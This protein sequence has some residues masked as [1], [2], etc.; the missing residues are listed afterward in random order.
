MNPDFS[1]NYSIPGYT[2]ITKCGKQ[3]NK[4]VK[5]RSGGLLCYMKDSISSGINQI[6]GIVENDDRLWLKLHSSFFTLRNDVYIICC[7]YITPATSTSTSARENIWP[8]LTTEVAKFSRQGDIL[9]TGNFNARTSDLPDYNQYDSLP[10]PAD[11]TSD[12]GQTRC[13]SDH[14]VYSYGKVLLNLCI[15]SNLRIVNGRIGTDRNVGEFTCYSPRG[16][17]VVDYFVVSAHLMSYISDMSVSDHSEYSDHCPI[18]L[19][20]KSQITSITPPKPIQKCDATNDGVSPDRL[21]LKLNGRDR[22]AE[23]HGE[24]EG[25]GVGCAPS[26]AKRKLKL[27]LHCKVY[28]SLILADSDQYKL[29]YI[30]YRSK[31]KLCWLQKSGYEEGVVVSP[32]RCCLTCTPLPC[33]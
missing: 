7:N 22:V 17:S 9:L 10:L 19:S 33:S 4:R 32:G 31:R 14:S 1:F 12:I 6:D 21:H 18:I 5:R 24:G 11:Y 30:V 28:W 13:N 3:T 25:V 15:S 27:L 16:C 2:M 23:S 20:L 29:F 26:R 8:L